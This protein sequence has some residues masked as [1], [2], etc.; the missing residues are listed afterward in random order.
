MRRA[1]SPWLGLVVAVT[2]T[3]VA[4]AQVSRA[5]ENRDLLKTAPLPVPDY[6]ETVTDPTFST[7][8]TRVTDP[9]ALFL[10]GVVCGPKACRHRY[11][12][13]QAWN[14]DQS[15]LLI[16]EGCPGLCFVDGQTY[17]P[18]FVRQ[19][20]GSHDCKW[21]PRD[22]DIMVCVYPSGVS[23]WNPRSRTW[24]SLWKT[25]DYR[26]LVFGPYKGNLSADGDLIV[27]RGLDAEGK[28]V[29]FALDLRD[30]QKHPDIMLD[31]LEGENHYATISPSGRYVYVAQ[32]TDDGHEPAYVFTTDGKL[33]Q[34]WPE[35]HRPGHGDMTIDADGEDVY[36]GVSKS[37]PDKFHV[38]KRRLSD[39]AVTSLIPYSNASHISARNIKLPGWVFVS[40]SGSYANTRKLDYPAPYY[41]EVVALRIDGSGEVHRLAHTY[42]ADAEYLSEAHG[43]PSPDGSRVI[44]A[45]NW[46]KPGAPVSAFVTTW[47]PPKAT[48]RT[49]EAQ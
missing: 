22:P 21:H 31:G 27:L 20:S 44:W 28:L 42:G 7:T 9:E 14:A 24:K 49:S 29:A 46:G 15:L 5:S 32:R 2:I 18:L 40:F 3:V 25:E 45:S 8:F 13:T 4:V 33:I 30:G 34:H 35:H 10:P 6:L 48:S 41:Q 47:N 12:S 17:E 11:S 38:V 43:S 16:T 1:F 37:E 23:A 26:A 39:G 19:V 36:V